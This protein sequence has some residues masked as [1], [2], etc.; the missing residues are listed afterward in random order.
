VSASLSGIPAFDSAPA[1]PDEPAAAPGGLHS[2]SSGDACHGSAFDLASIPDTCRI[3][4]ANASV[5]PPDAFEVRIAPAARTV[6]AGA[7]L[8]VSVEMVNSSKED[9][10]IVF[11]PSCAELT[12]SVWRNNKRADFINDVCGFGIRIT[13]PDAC[14]HASSSFGTEVPARIHVTGAYRSGS[15]L[16]LEASS[17]RMFLGRFTLDRFF[18]A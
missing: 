11:V 15:L 8:V 3:G 4:A 13:G 14:G 5:T 6:R 18:Q 2:E 9:A 7:E 17:F 10:A 1:K 16:H 12:T